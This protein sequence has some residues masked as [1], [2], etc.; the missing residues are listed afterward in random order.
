MIELYTWDTPNGRKVSIM[1]EECGL[2]YRVHKVDLGKGEQFA[3]EFVALNP[4]AK[5]PVIVDSDGPEDGKPITLMES[6]AILVYLAG[7]T[8]RFLHSSVRARYKTLEWLMFQ[9]GGVGPMFGQLHV[10][11]KLA[12]PVPYAMERYTREKDRLYGVLDRRLGEVEYLAGDYSIADIATY[13]WVARHNFHK[14]DFAAFPNVKRWFDAISA[15]P[16]VVRGMRVP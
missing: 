1:L 15:R 4:N 5:I 14:V 9:M 7:K 6:G 16:A 2:P 11:L 3:P 13:P 10:F 8:G 12:E